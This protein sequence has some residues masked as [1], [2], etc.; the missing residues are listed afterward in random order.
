MVIVFL[1]NAFLR[2]LSLKERHLT[3]EQGE[4]FLTSSIMILFVTRPKGGTFNIF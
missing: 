2:E 3:K 4:L 1:S